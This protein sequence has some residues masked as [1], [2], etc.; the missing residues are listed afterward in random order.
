MAIAENTAHFSDELAGFSLRWT[1]SLTGVATIEGVD[2]LADTESTEGVEFLA[3][4]GTTWGVDLVFFIV[5]T[6]QITEE[7]G[8]KWIEL[9]I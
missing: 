6:T 2:F 4:L 5:E 7:E 8:T 3:D 1:V 9:K